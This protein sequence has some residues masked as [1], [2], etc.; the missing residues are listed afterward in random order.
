MQFDQ[1]GNYDLLSAGIVHRAD[2]SLIRLDLSPSLRS[3][4][5]KVP[6]FRGLS[7]IN[8]LFSLVRWRELTKWGQVRYG[9][10]Q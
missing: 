8:Y 5:P 9:S 10:P 1:K 6:L 2:R 7:D 3:H 4:L